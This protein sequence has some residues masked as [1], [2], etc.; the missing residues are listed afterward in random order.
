MIEIQMS[1][2]LCYAL[3][4]L[5]YAVSIIVMCTSSSFAA[6][7]LYTKSRRAFICYLITA[8][9]WAGGILPM[10]SWDLTR[11]YARLAELRGW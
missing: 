8:M 10:A 11:W 1:P 4:L 9:I 3:A 7:M 6:I 2:E 5:R